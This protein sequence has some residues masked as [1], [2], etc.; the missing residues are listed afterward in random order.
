MTSLSEIK[1]TLS[2]NQVIIPNRVNKLDVDKLKVYQGYKPIEVEILEDFTTVLTDYLNIQ[3]EDWLPIVSPITAEVYWEEKKTRYIENHKQ[4]HIMNYENDYM[5]LQL[6]S[7]SFTC[8]ELGWLEIYQPGKGLGTDIL[9]TILDV[10]DDMRIDIRVLPVDFKCGNTKPIE[11][12]RWLRSW[13]K[14]FNFK[15]YSKKSPALKY[16]NNSQK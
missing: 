12:L 14:S 3:Q 15:S 5:K 10:A 1:D 6:Y 13:Y 16:Y 11:Y 9:N 4:L 8:I 2:P 7:H